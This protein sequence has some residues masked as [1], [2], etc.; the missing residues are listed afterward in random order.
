MRLNWYQI[1]SSK[2]EKVTESGNFFFLE[3]F[4]I[5]K[6]GDQI[7]LGMKIYFTTDS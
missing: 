2:V 6:F 5:L 1:R 4:K 3:I 7:K